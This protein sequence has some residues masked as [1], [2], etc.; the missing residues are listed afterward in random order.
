MSL[1]TVS[2]DDFVSFLVPPVVKIPLDFMVNFLWEHIELPSISTYLRL[3]LITV[4]SCM[5]F[6]GV[7]PTE[8]PAGLPD[9]LHEYWYLV[10]AS[11]VGM[12]AGF[13]S[14]L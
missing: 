1:T 9:Y 7:L 3:I 8:L 6:V 10:L 2:F 12:W 11:L 13:I 14:M 5:T 4:G